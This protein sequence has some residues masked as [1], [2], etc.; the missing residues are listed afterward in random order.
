MNDTD[1]RPVIRP[2]HRRNG[3]RATVRKHDGLLCIDGAF[4]T[5]RQFAVRHGI[6]Y[7]VLRR[8]YNAIAKQPGP[9]TAAALLTPVP[10]V[11]NAGQVPA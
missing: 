5:L 11:R 9:V 1:H 6:G 7:D 4:T 10:R 8:R 2:E 3:A